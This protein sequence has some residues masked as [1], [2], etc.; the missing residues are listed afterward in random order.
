MIDRRALAVACAGSFVAA[1]STSLVAVSVPVIADELAVTPGDASWVLTTYLLATSCLL[2]LSGR[3]ADVLGRKRIYLT[4]FVFY[5]AASLMCAGAPALRALLGA[6]AMQGAGAAM[7][8]AVSP[9]I[10][11]RAVPPDRRARGLGIQLAATY[12][13]LTIGPSVGGVLASSVGWHALFVLVAIVAS[14]AG[15]V[16]LIVLEP[17]VPRPEGE[18]RPSLD[19]S[20][21]VLLAAG[22]GGLL[23]AIHTAGRHGFA[24]RLPLALGAFAVVAL[25]AFVRH[26]RIHPSPLLPAS[27][28]GK[29]AF[30]LGVLGAT[31]LYVVTFML[32]FTLPFHL[33]RALGLSPQ[34]AG[35]LMTAQPATMAIV[36][37]AS[38]WIADR[39]GSKLPA[40][41]GMLAIAAG[42]LLVSRSPSSIA[43]LGL[44]G[45]GAGLYVAPNNAVIMT[46]APKDRQATAAAMAATARNVGMTCGVALSATLARS[47]GFTHTL[48]VAAGLAAAGAV[49]ALI[50]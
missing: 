16:A 19:L 30:S 40:T 34:A 9:A 28:L 37:P 1:L 42:M 36:A 13:G 12:V 41:A 47:I 8:M 45:I 17:D 48:H 38:G 20:G 4:G 25:Y 46:A 6:R 43:A 32:A 35:A 50:R 27:L 5:V 39:W 15:I 29:P 2:A 21:A 24:A 11:T 33:Q 3:A 31:L 18:P 10:V 26:G 23:V 14:A 49:L 22:L 7:L 44:V